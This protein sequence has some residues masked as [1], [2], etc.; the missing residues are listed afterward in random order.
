MALATIQD[1]LSQGDVL[2]IKVEESC[3]YPAAHPRL[4]LA[5]AIPK[6][7][8]QA[9]MFSM[10]VQA[11]MNGYMPLECDH[12]AVRYRP[13]M[14]NRWNNVILQS[15]KQCRQPYT[16]TLHP[17]LSVEQLLALNL[18]SVLDGKRLLIVGDPEGEPLES[19]MSVNP[20]HLEE[21]ILV[22]GPEGGFSDS[23][24]KLLSAQKIL[25]LRLSNHVLRIET[26][27]IALCAVLHQKITL[28]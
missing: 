17:A 3:L 8:R 4:V 28:N 10:A 12:S 19:M 1:R 9:V 7:N 24:K 13:H 2:R 5:S 22:V 14:R 26:A 23:E 16:P 27:A 18:Q 6:G 20:P 15:C 11:G 25:K 21:I